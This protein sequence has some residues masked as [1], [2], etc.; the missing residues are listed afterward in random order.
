MTFIFD[1]TDY[2]VYEHQLHLNVCVNFSNASTSI[3]NFLNQT[4]DIELQTQDMTA[5]KYL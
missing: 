5:R 1:Q 3:G 2:L 4:I